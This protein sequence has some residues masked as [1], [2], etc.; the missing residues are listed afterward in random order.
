MKVLSQT[1]EQL[2]NRGKAKQI[3]QD[4]INMTALGD[5]NFNPQLISQQLAETEQPG[6]GSGGGEIRG[7]IGS[8]GG[9]IRGNIGSGGGEIQGASGSAG[10]GPGPTVKDTFN[11]GSWDPS[12]ASMAEIDQSGAGSA[13]KGYGDLESGDVAMISENQE[14]VLSGNFPNIGNTEGGGGDTTS[15]DGETPD[16][17]GSAGPGSGS[18]DPTEVS[19]ATADLVS[20]ADGASSTDITPS[21]GD[22]TTML[23]SIGVN[24]ST[25]DPQPGDTNNE[26]SIA[27]Q[28]H[29]SLT[30]GASIPDY[31][32]N[33]ESVPEGA[34][35][36]A[37]SGSGGFADIISG[38][39]QPSTDG[40][41]GSGS[42]SADTTPRQDAAAKAQ[43]R[44]DK[45]A[46]DA[47][48][49]AAAAAAG[50]EG[51]GEGEGEGGGG[52]LGLTSALGILQALQGEDGEGSSSGQT[53]AEDAQTSGGSGDTLADAE[54]SGETE[55]GPGGETPSDEDVDALSTGMEGLGNAY[56]NFVKD[57]ADTP[58]ADQS[59]ADQAIRGTLAA[60][61][62][63][64]AFNNAAAESEAW[65]DGEISATLM[66]VAAINELANTSA[67][68][69]DEFNYGTSYLGMQADI[70]EDAATNTAIRDLVSKG[71]DADTTLNQTQLEGDIA[72]NL[73]LTEGDIAAD[74]ID[75]QSDADV[76]LVGAQ[77]EATHHQIMDQGYVDANLIAANNV[78]DLNTIS[79]TGDE[80]RDTITTQ[81]QVD[82]SNIF[83]T[84]LSNIAQ[85]QAGSVANIS[86]I[87]AKGDVDEDLIGAQATADQMTTL[88]QGYVDVGNIAAT[89]TGNVNEII[90]S[91]IQERG[92]IG[93][94]TAGEL[95]TTAAEGA[96]TRSNMETQGLETRANMETEG[97]ETRLTESNRA[98][99]ERDTIGVQ[100]AETRATDTNRLTVEGAETR[101]SDSNRGK[102]TRLTD[103][104]RATED[105]STMSHDNRL[106]AK[107]KASQ[108]QYAS[109]LAR[110]F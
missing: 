97:G 49:A 65:T 26:T 6:A 47:A 24:P 60:T 29:A 76:A 53:M 35:G 55:F 30:S 34:G 1:P 54:N 68:M 88:T 110:S 36:E 8:D 18:W 33:P 74:T 80:T 94:Q 43:A 22:L 28:I 48:A 17:P 95:L 12:Q 87:E 108:H 99:E 14:N 51:E 58:A 50:A 69:A 32:S 77:S 19:G 82:Q 72:E 39:T 85:T 62:A 10:A 98:E 2:A 9:E 102:E 96:E 64:S 40:R 105:R 44:E 57:W 86:E 91:G 41:F 46:A 42:D 27:S 93:A 3:G 92:N 15:G 90:A 84:G 59:E 71:F 79:A 73:L 37:G 25:V 21:S 103:S 106:K 7:N 16:A 100:G 31:A 101:A 5:Q 78:A 63:M 23:T 45:K 83:A 52:D 75:A 89:S 67:I 20:S 104:N 107:T 56:T 70:A 38:F 13:S 4:H 61:I 11:Y 81:G 66:N 109:N